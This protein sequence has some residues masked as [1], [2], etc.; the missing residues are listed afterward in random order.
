VIGRP[1]HERGPGLA[2]GPGQSLDYLIRARARGQDQRQG[3]L[4]LIP[5]FGTEGRMLRCRHR[6]W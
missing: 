2:D 3:W 4:W 6:F 5:G 1:L